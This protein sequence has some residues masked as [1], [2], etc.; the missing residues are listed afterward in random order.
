VRRDHSVTKQPGQPTAERL[1]HRVAIGGLIRALA[2][3]IAVTTLYFTLPLG[4]LSKLPTP[5]NLTIGLLILAVVT[6]LEVRAVMRAR[7]P[8]LRAVESLAIIIPVFLFLFAATYYLFALGDT[9]NFSQSPLTRTDTLY[10]AVTTF[11]SVG[12]GDIAATSQAARLTVTAQMLLDLLLLGA[13]IRVFFGAVRFSL[14]KEPESL[15]EPEVCTPT[16]VVLGSIDA[17]SP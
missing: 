16:D 1:R 4:S 10:F 14:D 12:F 8:G 5:L 11:S 3:A 7:R 9:G 13:V 17:S 15:R 2:V 6:G